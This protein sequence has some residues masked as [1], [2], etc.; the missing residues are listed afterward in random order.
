[1]KK[2]APMIRFFLDKLKRDNVGAYAGQATLFIIMSV[3]PFMLVLT[4]LI[5]F[6]P[7]TEGMILSAIETVV[8][9]TLSPSLVK[10]ID[11][12]FHNSGRL[13]LAAIV[14]AVYSS[15]KAVQS[16]RYGLNTV[17]DIY[18]TRNWFVLRFRAMIET[19]MMILAIVLLMLLMVFGQKIQ[20]MLVQYAPIVSIVTDWILKLRIVLLFFI[21]IIFFATIYKVLPNRRATLRSQLV[22]AVGCAASWYVF[23]FGL[24][25]YVN[26]FKG[27]SLYGSLTTLL[28]MM[29]WLYICMY[30][31]MVCGEVNNVFEV[32]WL[33]IKEA[34][35]KKRMRKLKEKQKLEKK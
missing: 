21:L 9:E 17:Y 11:E 14:I 15:A 34:R 24:S 7:V 1:M 28:L 19:F 12:V 29:F 18:E 16:L 22:G 10:V 20:G 8:P 33:E 13:L 35:E 30:I 25:I 2:F 26:Y 5:R 6:T 27:F 23:S 4:Y 31:F 32:I 3:I